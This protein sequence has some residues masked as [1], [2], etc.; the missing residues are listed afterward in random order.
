[1]PDISMCI[2]A[3]CPSKDYCHRY[4]A[5]PSRRQSYGGFSLNEEEDKCD[6]FWP[7]GKDSEQCKHKGVKREG[8]MCNKEQ[9][10]YPNCIKDTYCTEC[11]KT[12][13]VHKVSCSTHK[14][15][16][17]FDQM[18]KEVHQNRSNLNK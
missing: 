14:V 2:N 5:K 17:F 18:D 8:E 12:E 15:T 11:H 6:M 7:N 10:S 9:C 3:L 13:G 1:M 4:T 16:I